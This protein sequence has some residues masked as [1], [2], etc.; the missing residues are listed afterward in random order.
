MVLVGCPKFDDADAYI[1]KM[2]QIIKNA[3]PKSIKAVHMEVPC[4]SGLVSIVKQAIK[5]TGSAGL[6]TRATISIKGKVLD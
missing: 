2:S 1:E 6:F 4:C 3:N 5:Q